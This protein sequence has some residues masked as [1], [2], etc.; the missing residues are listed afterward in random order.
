MIAKFGKSDLD[1]VDHILLRSLVGA[2]G[3]VP[4]KLYLEPASLTTTQVISVRRMIY[5]VQHR[6]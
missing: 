6:T 1:K 3:K 5:D 4:I 2:Q